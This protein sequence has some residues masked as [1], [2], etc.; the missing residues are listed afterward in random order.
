MDRISTTFSLMLR[1]INWYI[2]PEGCEGQYVVLWP[3]LVKDLCFI[4]GYAPRLV[5]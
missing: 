1:R 2:P 5:L 4:E 3:W